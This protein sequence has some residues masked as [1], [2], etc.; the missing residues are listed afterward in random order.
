MTEPKL[1]FDALDK[2]YNKVDKSL[3]LSSQERAQ[4]RHSTDPMDDPVIQTSVRMRTSDFDRFRLLAKNLRRSNG[5]LLQLLLDSF[6][7]REVLEQE[8]IEAKK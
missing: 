1:N 6:I 5:E 2:K 4:R 7:D 3:R 8:G